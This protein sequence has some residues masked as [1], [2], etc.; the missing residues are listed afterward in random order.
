M[1][2]NKSLKNDALYTVSCDMTH[3]RFAFVRSSRIR[4][5]GSWSFSRRLLP[6]HRFISLINRQI[7]NTKNNDMCWRCEQTDCRKSRKT[8]SPSNSF[9]K[10]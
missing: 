9:T 2:A 6:R 7:L 8:G 5:F 1:L 4:G 3:T 10:G